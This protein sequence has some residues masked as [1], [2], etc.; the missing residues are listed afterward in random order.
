MERVKNIILVCLFRLRVEI[1]RA[2]LVVGGPDKGLGYVTVSM[3]D[4]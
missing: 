3:P 2:T 4:A 1:P